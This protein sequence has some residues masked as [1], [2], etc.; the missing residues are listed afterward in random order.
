MSDTSSALVTVNWPV[1]PVIPA[2]ASA[3]ACSSHAEMMAAAAWFTMSACWSSRDMLP[4]GSVGS[5]NATLS[6]IARL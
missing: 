5:A 3:V 6:A 2:S 4:V 1:L